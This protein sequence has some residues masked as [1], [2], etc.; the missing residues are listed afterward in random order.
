MNR[1]V[2]GRLTFDVLKSAS[3]L[4]IIILMRDT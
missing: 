1:N 2:W 3:S 4:V